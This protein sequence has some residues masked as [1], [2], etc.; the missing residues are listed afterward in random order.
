MKRFVSFFMLILFSVSLLSSSFAAE[1]AVVVRPAGTKGNTVRMRQKPDGKVLV[2]I[3][4]DTEVEVLD[5]QGEWMKISFD[6]RTGW[7][8]S[9]FL[10]VSSPTEV[11]TSFDITGEWYE[12]YTVDDLATAA[13]R[14]EPANSRFGVDRFFAEDLLVPSDGRMHNIQLNSHGQYIFDNWTDYEVCVINNDELCILDGYGDDSVQVASL[15]F[16]DQDTMWYYGNNEHVAVCKRTEPV[17]GVLVNSTA[18]DSKI[19]AIEK[20]LDRKIYAFKN[21]FPDMYIGIADIHENVVYAE[22]WDFGR[23]LNEDVFETI[24]WEVYSTEDNMEIIHFT[25]SLRINGRLDS[26]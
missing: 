12:W 11:A 5:N 13:D 6:G 23:I 1:T 26:I 22:D 15:F 20:I 17:N 10:S 18:D 21:D 9:E 14:P 2:N 16:V 19:K 7:M 4:F 24:N 3:P 8:K 25:G